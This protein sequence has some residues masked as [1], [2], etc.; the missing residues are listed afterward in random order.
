MAVHVW[1][2]AGDSGEG[3]IFSCFAVSSRDRHERYGDSRAKVF[4]Q[5]DHS[6]GSLEAAGSPGSPSSSFFTF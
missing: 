3:T 4:Q 1:R 6:F 5:G 2:E